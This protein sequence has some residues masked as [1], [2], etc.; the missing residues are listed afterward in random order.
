MQQQALI[1]ELIDGLHNDS[2]PI[3]AGQKGLKNESD[4]VTA[5]PR[6]PGAYQADALQNITGNLQAADSVVRGAGALSVKT[7]P[8]AAV[9]IGSTAGAAGSIFFDASKS[10]G[11]R[12]SSETRSASSATLP[13]ILI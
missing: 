4:C 12:T 6:L 10:P 13:C 8:P 9:G 5:N 11:A 3:S 7:N 2:S 1:I